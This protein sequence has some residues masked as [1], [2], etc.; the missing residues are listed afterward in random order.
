MGPHP[1]SQDAAVPTVTITNAC[2][3]ETTAGNRSISTTNGHAD[4][5]LEK[6]AEVVSSDTIKIEPSFEEGEEKADDGA[7]TRSVSSD[8]GDGPHDV[9]LSNDRP[10]V[11]FSHLPLSF[12]HYK[13]QDDLQGTHAMNEHQALRDRISAHDT[14]G[15]HSEPASPITPDVSP[16]VFCFIQV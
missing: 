16:P 10:N 9:P 13:A 14:N 3:S 7:G 2:D 12:E 15:R 4:T 5:G 11:C 8:E 6:T 1:S